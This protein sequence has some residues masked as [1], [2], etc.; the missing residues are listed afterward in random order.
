[1][2]VP[3]GPTGAEDVEGAS[4]LGAI[5]GV[6]PAVVGVTVAHCDCCLEA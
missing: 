2:A 6:L 1:M 4:D 5:P 3:T